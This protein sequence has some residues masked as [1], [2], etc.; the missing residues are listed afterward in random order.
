MLHDVDYSSP[1]PY[2]WAD[3][4]QDAE[5]AHL[6]RL[7]LWAAVSVLAGTGVLAWLR[8]GGRRSDLLNHFAI[9]TAT[10]G[11]VIAGISAWLLPHLA[12]R[13]IAGATRLDRLLWLCVGLDTG[14]I[15]VGLTLGAVGLRLGRQM[16]LVGAG[17][18][19]VVQGCAL[20]LLDLMLATQVSR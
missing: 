5:R 18:G 4:L 15:V 8:A 3:T 17:M 12:P 11:A 19:V 6:L 9:Q 1:M 10:W 20:T 16:K 13:D 2:M 7:L 14:A